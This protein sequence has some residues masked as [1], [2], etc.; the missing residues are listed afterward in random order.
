MIG[1]R[2]NR[3]PVILCEV[4]VDLSTEFLL[5]KRADHHRLLN[6][7]GSLGFSLKSDKINTI[8]LDIFCKCFAL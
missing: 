4:S 2:C 3:K 5:I 8:K 6:L 7:C 1:N